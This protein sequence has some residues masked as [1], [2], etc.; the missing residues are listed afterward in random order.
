[1][2][3]FFLNRLR[4]VVPNLGNDR[5]LSKYETLQMAQTY[6]AALNELLKRD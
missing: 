4:D 3:F 1:V 6:I 5:K 2:K